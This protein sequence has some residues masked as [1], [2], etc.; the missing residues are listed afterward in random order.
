MSF[1]PGQRMTAVILG[2]VFMVFHGFPAVPQENRAEPA[3]TASTDV[4]LQ[5]STR[6][7]IKVQLIQSFIFP[8]LQGNGPLTADNNVKLAFTAEATPVSMNGI[9]EI[10]WTPA[11]F[12]Q[13]VGGGRAGSGWNMPLGNG[14]GFNV[15]AAGKDGAGRSYSEVRGKA[16][17]GL[18]WS[19][20]GGL[21]LQFD[22]GAVI[23]GDWTHVLF[24]AYSE[25]RYSAYT[26]AGSGDSWF[27]E[28]DSGENRNGWLW[29]GRFVLGYRIP[30]SVAAPISLLKLDTIAL[31]AE[32][33]QYRYNTPGGSRWGDDLS[34]WTFSGLFNFAITPRFSTAL[35][36][37][38]RTWRNFGSG[39]LEN[40]D[41]IWYQDLELRDD[42]GRR[43]IAFYRAALILGYKLR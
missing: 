43:R 34:R 20:Y 37:Q 27:F 33:E 4:G 15:P 1:Y 22:L 14:I 8:F 6:P 25:G 32:G 19:A 36:I 31:M 40:R 38:F 21:N 12:F 9:G 11:A 10:T 35:G 16:F 41:G 7:E 24:Q 17:D 26:R 29:R 13:V 23:P 28:N 42:Y 2:A 39:D 3:I 5:I 18:L 30:R